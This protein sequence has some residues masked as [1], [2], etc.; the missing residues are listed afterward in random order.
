MRDIDSGG[1]TNIS[2]AL[3]QGME[4][5]DGERPGTVIFLTDGLPT[6]GIDS[7]EGI[8]EVAERAAPER[9]QL[10]AFG[11][12]YDVDTIL[13]DA[14]AQAFVGSSHYVAPEQHIDTEVATLFEQVST[15]VLS[16]VV[17]SI[18]GVDTWDLAPAEMPG[19]FAGNQ[20]LLTGRYSGAGEAT[21]TVTGN[22]AAGRETFVYEVD[23][24]ERANDDPAIAQLW[25]QRRVA[26][27]LTELRIE[28][29]RDSLIEE[30]VDIATQFGIVTPYTAYLAE[31][32]ELALRDEAAMDVF[33][34]QSAALAEAP[35]AGQ[36]AVERA[37]AV[38]DLRA[39]NAI[40]AAPGG[41][42]VQ[43]LGTHAFYQVEGAWTRE[44]YETGTEAPEVEVGSPAFLALIGQ[45]PEIAEAAAL[46][47]R[48]ITLG[49][50]GWVTL[51][52]PEVATA[53]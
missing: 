9:T 17:I 21:V 19:I 11:V 48:V 49:P 33:T 24:P 51:V 31:E 35:A 47:E 12:G 40:S 32:P 38:D 5:L 13:L 30:I 14:L 45:S 36:D 6:V 7:P 22:A 28:G 26:D 41:E 16:D 46:G 37:K 39:G 1:N 15:P 34:E 29:S 52:W 50:D 10:F 2:G 4:F 53:E 3:E 20:A 42:A 25:A 27:L 8:L 44:D 43:T 23:F 18:D